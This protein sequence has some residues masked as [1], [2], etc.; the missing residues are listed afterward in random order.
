MYKRQTNHNNTT[1]NGNSYK[2]TVAYDPSKSA[3]FA[4]VQEDYGGHN[5]HE[6]P[7]AVQGR[8]YQPN[9]LIPGKVCC[10]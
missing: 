7:I 1:N 2:K 3:T 5:V 8:P 10:Q 9:R 6:I 4:A